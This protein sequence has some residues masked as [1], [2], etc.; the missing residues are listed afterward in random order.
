MREA[1]STSTRR[2][3]EPARRAGFMLLVGAV[4]LV[5]AVVPL[6]LNLGDLDDTYYGV[7]ARALSILAPVLFTGVL[8]VR[9]LPDLNRA[10]LLGPL[11]AFVVAV[12]LATAY[13]IDP[14][15]SVAGAPRRHEG[16]LS[17]IAYALTSAGTLIVVARAGPRVWHGAAVLGGTLVAVYGVAQYFGVEWLVRDAVRVNWWQAFSTT[18]NANFLGAYMVMMTPLAAAAV[19]TARRPAAM[20]LSACSLGL[21]VLAALCT[22]SRAAWLGLT[23]AVAVFGG[24]LLWRGRGAFHEPLGRPRL[25]GALGLLVVLAA[26][27]FVPGGPFAVPRADWSAAD[28]ARTAIQFAA[29]A[30]GFRQRVYLWHHALAL[31]RR[32][33]LTGYGPETLTL[34]LSQE[35]DAERVHL[36]GERPARIDK[37]HNDT[38]DMAMSIGLIGLTGFGWVLVTAVRRGWTALAAGGAEQV[39]AAACLAAIAGYWIDVQ[40]HFSVVS[41]APVFWSVMGAAGGMAL[42][43][44][45]AR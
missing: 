36:F 1:A 13:S 26:V 43:S 3:G 12:T 39:A 14:A 29:P 42:R 4:L 16:L 10:R 21:V 17:L 22:Y 40:W 15:W 9:G 41:V 6:L 20:V 45:R 37:A 19:L 25:R 33:P 35:W 5:V 2:P 23:V 11:V 44:E 27:F 28:R 18:G 32:R 31:L 38:V 8:A 30:A 24:T 7:K 34:V